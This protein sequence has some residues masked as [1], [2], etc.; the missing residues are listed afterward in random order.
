MAH[1]QQGTTHEP[2]G[3]GE[4]SRGLTGE[5][6]HEQGWGLEEEERKR[7]AAPPQDTDGGNDYNYGARDFGDEPQNM[8]GAGSKG[9]EQAARR[10]LGIDHK[11]ERK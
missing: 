4:H 2:R 1:E 3:L 7:Q 6:A 9:G 10:A 5:Y 11:K 8:A